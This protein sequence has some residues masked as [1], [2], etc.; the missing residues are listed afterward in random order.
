MQLNAQ[1]EKKDNSLEAGK[2]ALQFQINNNF[3]LSSFQGAIV[4]AKYQLTDSRAIRFGVGGNYAFREQNSFNE[5]FDTLNN[6]AGSN[7]NSKSYGLSIYSQ[8]LSYLNPNDEVLLFFG[9]GPVLQYSKINNDG[10]SHTF[11]GINN[12]LFT[13]NETVNG[14]SWGM[15]GSAILGVEWF[16]NKSISLHAEYGILLLYNWTT[17]TYTTISTSSQSSQP[18]T[19]IVHNSNQ[20]GWSLYANSV[21]FGLSVYF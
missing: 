7:Y 19:K 3:T 9:A 13:T 2:W 21:K 17:Q 5:P 12:I 4:S 6:Y 1:T 8:Y 15:G 16:A 10:S 18:V 20:R 14:H 11:D